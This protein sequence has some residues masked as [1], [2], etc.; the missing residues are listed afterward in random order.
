VIGKFQATLAGLLGLTFQ[1][2]AINYGAAN[3]VHADLSPKELSAAMQARGETPLAL[4]MRILRLSVDPKI[5][6]PSGGDAESADELKDINPVMLFLRGASQEER[7]RLKRFMARRMVDSDDFVKTLQGD[8][9]L[10]LIQDRNRAA[11]D[12]LSRELAAGKR[13]VAIFY[14]SA[15]LEG[16]HP[17]LVKRFNLKIASVE[18]IPAWV[19]PALEEKRG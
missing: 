13:K 2:D 3:F 14:G 9:G 16:M 15:H 17:E 8:V 6:A 4:F 12:V 10:S 5:R 18:W 7:L 1:L 19:V 11:L